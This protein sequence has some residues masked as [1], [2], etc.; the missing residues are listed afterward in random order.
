MTTTQPFERRPINAGTRFALQL[1]VFLLRRNWMGPANKFL[2][3]ITTTGRKS[4]KAYSLPIGYL[5]DSDGKTIIAYTAGGE[6]NWFKNLRTNPNVTL[7]IMSKSAPYRA[8]LVNMADDV[9]VLRILELY[10]AGAGPSIL[11][12]FFG[13][14][15]TATGAEL[16][17]ARERIKLTKFYPLS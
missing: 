9:E 2:M 11:E 10:K 16:L 13:V 8:E 6:S 4:G 1:Q 12:R 3:V 17:K 14:S 7:N 15:A 5:R